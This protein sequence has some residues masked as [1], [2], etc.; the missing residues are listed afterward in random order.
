[1]SERRLEAPRWEGLAGGRPDPR[2]FGSLRLYSVPLGSAGPASSRPAPSAPTTFALRPKSEWLSPEPDAKETGSRP[3]INGASS[4][5]VIV[6]LSNEP[7]LAN[8]Q[9]LAVGTLFKTPSLAVVASAGIAADGVEHT[10]QRGGGIEVCIKTDPPS[11]PPRSG[12]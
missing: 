7:L 10:T 9:G 8:T 5:S 2:P 4:H 12:S 3:Q 6:S 11:L 1:M